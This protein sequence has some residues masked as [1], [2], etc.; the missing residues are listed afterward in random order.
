MQD[1]PCD[2]GLCI[3]VI[4]FQLLEGMK[5]LIQHI[6]EQAWPVSS[7]EEVSAGTCLTSIGWHIKVRQLLVYMAPDWFIASA[8][9][10]VEAPLKDHIESESKS[11]TSKP[12]IY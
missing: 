5:Q 1:L 12:T 11:Q 10:S 2:N 8:K 9:M 3:E 4:F 7:L 6:K